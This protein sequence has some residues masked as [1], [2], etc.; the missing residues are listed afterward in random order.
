[1]IRKM[2]V[3]IASAVS[4]HGV[5]GVDMARDPRTELIGMGSDPI[6]DAVAVIADQIVECVQMFAHPPGLL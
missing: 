1:M 6:D 3:E 5:D 2:P 4:H